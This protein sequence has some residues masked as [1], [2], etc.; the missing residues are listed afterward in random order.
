M[1]VLG[2]AL[3]GVLAITAPIAAHPNRPGSKMPPANARSESGVV[4]VWDGSGSG[5]HSGATEGRR[6]AGRAQ[7][8]NRAG[9][10]SLGVKPSIRR[11]GSLWGA[12]GADLLGLGSQRRRLRL[13]LR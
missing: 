4:L 12:A 3:V 7:Q 8:W 2:L 11:V 6:T 9:L 13:P 1:R 10:C 5:G